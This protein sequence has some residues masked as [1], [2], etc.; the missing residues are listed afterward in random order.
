MVLASTS[1]LVD[2]LLQ[3][4]LL[5]PAQEN[6]L[7]SGLSAR[8]PDARTLARELMERNWLTPFQ[9]NLVFKGKAPELVLG[10]YLLLE[11]IG[12]G[13]MGQVYK[14]RHRLL[15]RVD[16][17]KV[18][19][20]D[21]LADPQTLA[22]FLKEVEAAARLRH[23]NLVTVYTADQAGTTHYLAMEHLD[24]SDLGKYLKAQSGG[25]AV[26]EA[27]DFVRQACL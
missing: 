23:A 18:I 21:R 19:R 15:K 13:G 17:L 20:P 7:T 22:R 14:A 6:E 24:G 25:L 5:T 27:C 12:E 2:E 3:H 4:R 26:G 11:R 16:A 9:A 10:Q 1:S 8:F